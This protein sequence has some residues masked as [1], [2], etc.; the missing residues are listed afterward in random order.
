MT[1]QLNTGSNSLPSLN[2][3]AVNPT[4]GGSVLNSLLPGGNAGM[5]PY[6]LPLLP[7]ILG[8]FMS[9][10]AIDDATKALTTGGQQ[11]ISTVQGSADKAAGTLSDVY[12][13]Q[14]DQLSPYTTAG[15]GA[16]SALASGVAPGG[17]LVAPF[18]GNPNFSYTPQDLQNDPGYQFRLQQGEAA[19]EANAA[20]TGKRFSGATA[21]ALSDYT[22]QSASQ[23]YNTA[24]QQQQG[25]FQEN[26]ANSSNQFY[27]NQGN[28]RAA[29]QNL[30][31]S[32][33]AAATTEVG[34]AGTYGTNLSNLQSGTG[35]AIADIQTQIAS[36]T[37][38]GDIAKANMLQATLTALTQGMTQAEIL[39]ATKSQPGT[40]INNTNTNSP[41]ATGGGGG[42]GGAGGNGTGGNGGPGAPAP[43][44]T[45]PP[46]PPAPPVAPPTPPI[47]PVPPPEP[48]PGPPGVSFPGS[49][50]DP[51][52][53][54]TP[55]I[56]PPLPIPQP[57]VAPPAPPP[58]TVSTEPPL[59][60]GPGVPGTP[61]PGGPSGTGFD[62]NGNPIDAQGNP[63]AGPGGESVSDNGYGSQYTDA[64]GDSYTY[65]QKTG[66][67]QQDSGSPDVGDQN[68]TI[69]PATGLPIL[70][71]GAAGAGA[72][73]AGLAGGGAAAGAEAGANVTSGLVASGAIPGASILSVPTGAAASAVTASAP[74][75]YSSFLGVPGLMAIGAAGLGVYALI[76]ASQSHQ[77]ADSWVQGVQN[78]F[79]KAMGT[80]FQSAVSAMNSGK[81]SQTDAIKTTMAMA[82]QFH[83]YQSSLNDFGTQ[84][85]KQSTIAK[86]ATA[87]FND[88]Y[89]ANGKKSLDTMAAYIQK[90]YG[91]AGYKALQQA[92]VN[93]YGDAW[94]WEP[95]DVSG[96]NPMQASA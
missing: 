42:A 13:Q 22:G 75:W 82:D 67:W 40:T 21:K 5:L 79:D 94:S 77:V 17:N 19:I 24:L 68:V 56:T 64:N 88:Q 41:S 27:T 76:K 30:A 44:I 2:N 58:G 57:P 51:N 36:A 45:L 90:N 7:S 11:A 33:Q 48:T 89:G 34:A 28:A 62:Q 47:P 72:T 31:G 80:Q 92:M 87:T 61:A 78:P 81:M 96:M 1:A 25:I 10:G 65:N 70:G 9:T 23:E 20:A 6:L 54:G 15:T 26:Y 43:P 69:D 91:D 35:K 16:E 12:G 84:G 46:G 60:G 3:P 4:T 29:L 66:Q 85:D 74:A 71:A 93:Q 55:P 95:G 38:S 86:Q 8:G 14:K 83:G 53:P 63:T 37:A 52:P 73:A 49:G 32:G 18:T 50:V 59:P 39:A